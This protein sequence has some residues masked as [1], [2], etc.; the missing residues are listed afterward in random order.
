L[1]LLILWFFLRRRASFKALGFARGPVPSDVGKAIL[2][3]VVYFF[4]LWLALGLAGYLFHTNIDQ[5]QELG[6]DNISGTLNLTLTFISLV[7]LPPAVEELLFRGV[8]FGGLRTRMSFRATALITSVLF[9]VPHLLE[10]GGG[11]LLWVAGIDTFILSLV[12]CYLREKTGNL[13]AGIILHT[14]KNAI[15]FAALYVVVPTIHLHP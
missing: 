7:V 2:A 3:G 14:L 10:S 12:L 5:K 8:L 13:W 4:L 15:A 6:F 1:T 9:A 11:G